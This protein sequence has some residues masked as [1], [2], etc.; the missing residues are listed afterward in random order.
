M[1]GTRERRNPLIVVAA[2]GFVALTGCT[3][4]AAPSPAVSPDAVVPSAAPTPGASASIE[5]ALDADRAALPLSENRI[6]EWADAA[7]AATDEESI[8][9]VFRGWISQTNGPSFVAEYSTLDSGSYE[10]VF[11]CRGDSTL[12]VEYTT[13][14]LTPVG[15][16][17]CSDSTVATSVT[18]PSAGLRAQLRLDGDGSPTVWAAS[19]RATPET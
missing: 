18:T 12:T 1:D 15:T 9:A 3:G 19:F 2:V 14:D 17:R 4:E 8:E 6:G 7:V 13:S 16:A 5:A 10:I 11:A